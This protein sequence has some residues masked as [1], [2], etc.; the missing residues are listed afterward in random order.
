MS[1]KGIY[2]RTLDYSLKKFDT[3]LKIKKEREIGGGELVAELRKIVS[4]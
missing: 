2:G 1:G 4:S 3:E